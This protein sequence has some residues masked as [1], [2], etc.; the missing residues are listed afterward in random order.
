MYIHY[1]WHTPQTKRRERFALPSAKIMPKRRK[2]LT[3]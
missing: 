3:D 2:R 1:F